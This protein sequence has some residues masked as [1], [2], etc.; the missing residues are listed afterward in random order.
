MSPAERR[1]PGIL[2]TAAVT[3]ARNRSLYLRTTVALQAA[4]VLVVVPIVALLLRA[5]LRAAGLTA[6]TEATAV[7][8]LT[9]PVSFLLLLLLA[10]VASVA[11]LIGQGVLILIGTRLR[12]DSI[13]HPRAIGAELA[14]VGRRLLGPQLLVFVAYAFL[15]VPLGGLEV[16]AFLTRGVEL[17]PFVAGELRK[18]VVGTL[19][20]MLGAVAV[21]Y[22]NVRLVLVPAVLLTSRVSVLAALASSWRMTRGQSARVVGLFAA[23][24]TVSAVVLGGLVVLILYAVRLADAVWP[25]AT[26]LVAGLTVTVVQV[27]VL[28]VSGL[29]VAV[30]TQALVV[31]ADRRREH[32]GDIGWL[33]TAPLDAPDT[34]PPPEASRAAGWVPRW[35]GMPGG[36]A[37]GVAVLGAVL[38][39]AV[40]VN[41]TVMIAVRDEVTTAV[42]AHRGVTD[43]AVEN[44]LDALDAAAAVGA[45]YVELDVQQAADGGLVVVHD[46]NL[47]RIAGINRSVFELTTAELTG[48]TVRQGGHTATI[49]TFEEFA[50]R[51][52][53]LDI[54]LLVEL[55][56]HGRE[57]GDYVGDVVAVLVAHGLVATARV[58]AFDIALVNEIEG[59]FSDVTT[60]W[61]VAFHRGRLHP[62]RADF[63]AL[64]ESSYTPRILSEA[65][66][67]GAELLLWT[68][69][70]P[71]AM[72]RF[73]RDGVDGLIT[74][75]PAGA[76]DQRAA[77]A[78][79]T[80][81]ARRLEDELH[82]LVGWW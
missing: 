37:V 73:V 45:D 39:V 72:R 44:T 63:V 58:Q 36:R 48:T 74:S 19:V 61:V 4:T 28:A 76:L 25:P 30:L 26:P 9:H 55:K 13:L 23:A 41:T 8:L 46:T 59:R 70:D 20:W 60:G 12:D 47:R 2:A 69:N 71:A 18:T 33:T 77:V 21:L 10:A 15:L 79:D 11:V 40:T 5:A 3:V 6:L 64:E 49:P 29:I 17:P 52:A 16:G 1:R 34:E 38:A 53:E 65:H 50:A 56:T 62:G 7:R 24:W 68:V 42:I 27:A 82:K 43:D 66:A 14:A 57:Q 32:G 51:A 81:L 54:A 31:L 35:T 80:S 78:A 67:A 22:V 75:D